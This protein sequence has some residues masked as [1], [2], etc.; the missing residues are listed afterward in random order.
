MYCVPD[1]LQNPN[2]K[3]PNEEAEKYFVLISFNG[4]NYVTAKKRVDVATNS[5]DYDQL[6]GQQNEIVVN[7]TVSGN[8]DKSIRFSVNMITSSKDKRSKLFGRCG[9]IKVKDLKISNFVGQE[10]RIVPV[11]RVDVE[12]SLV[13]IFS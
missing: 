12:A 8:R 11:E 10:K 9:G 13:V 4:E 6:T 5:I 2:S 1:S 3:L 7:L